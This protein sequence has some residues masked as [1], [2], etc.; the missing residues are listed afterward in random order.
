MMYWLRA[1]LKRGK[2][3]SPQLR[4][5]GSTD[6]ESEGLKPA[7]LQGAPPSSVLRASARK[8]RA[9]LTKTATVPELAATSGSKTF[10]YA[11]PVKPPR[12]ATLGLQQHGIVVE[13]QHF[14]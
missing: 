6:G 14:G 2:A 8:W 4:Y 3:T 11:F 9:C 1:A 5:D 13:G 12:W 10:K 7:D